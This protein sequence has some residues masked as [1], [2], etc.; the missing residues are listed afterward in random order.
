MD[1]DDEKQNAT[2]AGNASVLSIKTFWLR[3]ASAALDRA[4]AADP[5]SKEA[6]LATAMLHAANLDPAEAAGAARAAADAGNAAEA[7]RA[8]ALWGL[9]SLVGKSAFPSSAAYLSTNASYASARRARE[10]SRPDAVAALALGLCAEARGRDAEAHAAFEAASLLAE[11]WNAR[12]T[13]NA[14][15]EMAFASA[16]EAEARRGA[17]RVA[18]SKALPVAPRA[19]SKPLEKGGFL[20]TE[21]VR[22]ATAVAIADVH[23]RPWDV[24][25]R[26]ELASLLSASETSRLKS[27]CASRVVPE[28]HAAQ[29]ARAS[30]VSSAE[31]T[32]NAAVVAAAA[33]LAATPAGAG[34]SAEAD[35]RAIGIRLARAIREHPA[36]ASATR[37]RALLALVA[38]RRAGAGE[39]FGASETEALAFAKRAATLCATLAGIVADAGTDAR[40]AT[41]LLCAASEASAFAGDAELSSA[42]AAKASAAAEGADDA[43][44]RLANAQARRARAVANDPQIRALVGRLGVRPGERGFRF[45]VAPPL[46]GVGARRGRLARRGAVPARGNARAR[47]FRRAGGARRRRRRRR[48][49]SCSARRSARETSRRRE[50]KPARSFAKATRGA[51]VGGVGVRAATEACARV[52]RAT[53]MEGKS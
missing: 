50:R 14:G 35:A 39:L 30:E 44:R 41:S 31:S 9:S 21:G 42:L 34:A 53:G 5:G 43:A 29:I 6:W 2:S 22:E 18:P 13:K 8:R 24:L 10:A 28:A 26:A 51:A 25:K 17:A 16:V 27:F 1:D 3:R 4:R 49:A 33:A 52:A 40:L 32:T 11:S 37:A 45:R 47:V 12:G 15:N 48:R 23:A 20:D 7:H 36:C 46:R 19:V 38:A